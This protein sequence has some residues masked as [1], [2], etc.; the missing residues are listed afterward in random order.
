[1]KYLATN[2]GVQ[3]YNVSKYEEMKTNAH[4]RLNI[5]AALCF[6]RFSVLQKSHAF[7]YLNDCMYVELVLEKLNN[8]K[9]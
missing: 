1:V 6:A 8:E 9:S 7:N 4:E 5:P 3:P 2:H